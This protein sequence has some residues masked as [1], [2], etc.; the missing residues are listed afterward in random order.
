MRCFFLLGHFFVDEDFIRWYNS[1]EKMAD[2]CDIKAETDLKGLTG[3]MDINR[4]ERLE[5]G[6]YNL[7]DKLKNHIVKRSEAAFAKADRARDNIKT[8]EELRKYVDSMREKFIA[9]MGGIPYDKSL[10]LEAVT[11]GVIEEEHL[12]IEKVIFKSR[13]GVYVTANLYIPKVRK[14]KCGAVLCQCGHA[15]DGKASD[16]YQKSVR[17]IASSGLIVLCMDPVGQG[18]RLSYLEDGISAPVIPACTAD[19]QYAGDQC[20]LAGDT[21]T[22]YFI[23][24]AMRAVDYLESRPEV[25]ADKIGACGTSGGGTATCHMMVCDERIK[26][27]AP[28]TFVTNRREYLYADSVQDAEQIWMGATENGFDHNEL[29][30]CFAPNPL[31]ILAVD[32]DFF[33]IEGTKEVFEKS[34][35]FWDMHGKEDD[36][37]L[38]IDRSLHAFTDGL[39]IAAGKFFAKHLNGEDRTYIKEA[40]FSLPVRELNCTKSGQVKF[41]YPDAVFVYDE[42]LKRLS[43]FKKNHDIKAAKE[44][45][46]EKVDFMREPSELNVR[47]PLAS[48]IYDSGYVIDDRMW[49]SQKQMP[50]FAL[51][52]KKMN[53]KDEKLPVVICL[54][55]KGTDD[56]EGNI[57]KIRKLCNEKKMVVVLD[58]SGVGKTLPLVSALG[59]PL[60]RRFGFVDFMAKNL[61]FLGDSLCALRLFELEYAV[62]ALE[63]EFGTSDISIYAE[64][65]MTILA[66]L[67]KLLHEEMT[68]ELE[69]EESLSGIATEKYYEDHN[70][71]GFL[72]PGILKY[73]EI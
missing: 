37:E 65:K 36:L 73:I 52:F 18:E 46:R 55:D 30:M 23:A 11:T 49:F 25:D 8:K 22:R 10:P 48:P 53:Y 16:R 60:R 15:A 42:N 34:K 63:K 38:F 70:C 31:M 33:V 43:E 3:N 57:Y 1:G 6:F 50:T 68:I 45:L 21:I 44:F 19:H 26:A 67:Y 58:V 7:K 51:T 29:L 4:Y 20:I 40:V 24:D 64:G 66:K 27:A 59:T 61:F 72:I 56:I 69:R 9:S 41:D 32:S 71:A 35:R 39:A 47:R 12:T 5:V 28:G 2:F 17:E 62:S 54:W 13:P 14:E